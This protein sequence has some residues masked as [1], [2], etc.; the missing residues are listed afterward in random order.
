MALPRNTFEPHSARQLCALGLAPLFKTDADASEPFPLVVIDREVSGARIITMAS[1][2]E[3]VIVYQ[4]FN[5]AVALRKLLGDDM[6]LTK[7]LSDN[8][9]DAHLGHAVAR[10]SFTPSQPKKPGRID[11]TSWHASARSVVEMRRMRATLPPGMGVGYAKNVLE[12][13]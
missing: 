5:K 12:A 9:V 1:G 6:L 4:P 7:V 8:N 11:I 2:T 10:I 13:A 3:A